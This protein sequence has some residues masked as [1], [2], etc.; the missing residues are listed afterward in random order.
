MTERFGPVW[1]VQLLRA[2]RR[3][4]AGRH[5]ELS[6][7]SSADDSPG[8]PTAALIDTVLKAGLRALEIDLAEVRDRSSSAGKLVSLYPGE[9]YRLL[10]ALV[11]SIKPSLVVEVGTFTGLSA[12]AILSTLPKD[13]TLVTYDITPW[14]KFDDTVLTASDFVGGRLKQ[15]IGNLAQPDYFSQNAELLRSASMVFIDGPKDGR[16]EPQFFGLLMT[17]RREK[18]AWVIFDDIRLWKMTKF[19][20]DIGLPKFDATSVGHWSGT[21]ICVLPAARDISD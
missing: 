13:G 2:L 5:T 7:I 16:F 14:D 18:P 3:P 15:R 1:S 17:V 11:E 10:A 19:W 20:R 4:F 8:Q 12:L 21:G 9:H 6:V